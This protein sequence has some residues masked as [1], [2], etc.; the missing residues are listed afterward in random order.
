MKKAVIE[1]GTNSVKLITGESMAD[2][3]ARILYDVNAITKLGEGLREEGR[4]S[5]AAI[6]RTVQAIGKFAEFARFEGA[7]EIEAVG[8]MALRTAENAEEFL[9]RAYA[10]SGLK[11]RVIPG[12]EEAA[13]SSGAMLGS[14]AGASAGDT[15]LIDTGGGSTE[16]VYAKDGTPERSFS[17]AIG[18]VTLT[19]EAFSASPVPH[20]KVCSVIAGLTKGLASDGVTGGVRMAIAA[21]GNVTALASVAAGLENYDPNKIHGSLLSKAEVARQI[22][23]YA[24]KTPEERRN[25]KGLAPQRADIILAGACILMAVMEAAR[26]D[27]VTVS[28]RSLRHELLMRMFAQAGR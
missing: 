1:I 11:I 22:A 18:A 14:V 16:F 10:I 6:E 28:D 15:L 17:I 19:E 2:G 9:R 23:L 5:A 8:T 20:A 7:V 13:L 27:E 25:I 24:D 12:E 4:L 26:V 21:G 3:G